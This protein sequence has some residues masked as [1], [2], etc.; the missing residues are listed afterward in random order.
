MKPAIV[1]IDMQN[2]F[3]Q[4]DPLKSVKPSLVEKIN[5]LT[6]FARLREIPVIWVRQ[7]YSPDL[8][9]T[10]LHAK[11]TNR[12]ITIRGTSG[13]EILSELKRDNKDAIIIKKRYSAF[14]R[15]DFDEIIQKLRLDILILAGINTHACVRTTAIDAFQRDIEVIIAKECISSWNQ[16]HHDISLEYFEKSM[17]IGLL[18][19]EQLKGV[20]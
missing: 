17:S 1:I 20:F 18:S 12:R 2:D 3:F 9:D 5:E 19:N 6:D 13:A 10:N 7:E 14:F 11:K 15:T 16:E 8:S 4:E